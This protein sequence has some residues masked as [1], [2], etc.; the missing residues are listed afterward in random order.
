MGS[1]FQSSKFM[2]QSKVCMMQKKDIVSVKALSPFLKD[3]WEGR[4]VVI[5]EDFKDND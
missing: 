4:N 1:L 2:F 5:G 3:G